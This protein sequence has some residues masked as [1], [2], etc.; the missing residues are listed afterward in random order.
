MASAYVYAHVDTRELVYTHTNSKASKQGREKETV[1][2][3]GWKEGE[4]GELLP[5]VCGLLAAR[6]RAMAWGA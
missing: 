5:F 3:E 4:R 1:K 2:K 6:L